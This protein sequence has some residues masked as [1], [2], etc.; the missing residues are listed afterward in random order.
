MTWK[1]RVAAALV[2]A[3]VPSASAANV[4]CQDCWSDRC[5]DL[6]ESGHPQCPPDSSP[7][8]S[9]VP[10][11]RPTKP[12]A[13]TSAPGIAC[14]SGMALVPGGSFTLGDRRDR[15]TIGSLCMDATEV[16]VAAYTQCVR[17][18]RCTPASTVV[19][20]PGIT[21]P[22]R[23]SASAFCNGDRPETAGPSGQ[24]RGLESGTVLLR[25]RSETPTDR[26]R[27]GVGGAGWNEGHPIP[28]GK[29]PTRGPTVLESRRRRCAG[30][31]PGRVVRLG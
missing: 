14:P 2:L 18:G 25:R 10:P 22:V 20:W 12:S 28:M 13:S 17:Q 23:I 21:E 11:S 1:D 3:G 16:T 19:D 29:C 9:P 15:A 8:P 7:A 6:R 30:H 5:L 26:R 27:V 24:L 31:L 4:E